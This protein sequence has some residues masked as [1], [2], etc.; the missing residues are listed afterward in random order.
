LGLRGPGRLGRVVDADDEH[1][2][3]GQ[4]AGTGGVLRREDR[5]V[6]E[7]PGQRE[8]R[9]AGELRAFGLVG[10]LDAHWKK[11]PDVLDRSLID[12]RVT[13]RATLDVRQAALSVVLSALRNQQKALRIVVD[14]RRCDGRLTGRSPLRRG[15]PR[16]IGPWG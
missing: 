4:R 13:T 14:G 9:W 1:A 16:S 12:S 6:V 10:R 5:E 8:V 3:T 7:Q 2:A 11:S 15:C